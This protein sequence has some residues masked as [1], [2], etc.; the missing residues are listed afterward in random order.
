MKTLFLGEL[1]HGLVLV[2]AI[3]LAHPVLAQWQGSHY[4]SSHHQDN[5]DEFI[6]NAGYHVNAAGDPVFEDP[7][8]SRHYHGNYYNHEKTRNHSHPCK[9]TNPDVPKDK[10]NCSL[11]DDDWDQVNNWWDHCPNTPRGVVVDTYGCPF[12]DADAD[13]VHDV[14]DNCDNTSVFA[15]VNGYGCPVDSDLDGVADHNDDCDSTSKGLRVDRFGCPLD[16]DSDGVVDGSDSCVWSRYG[17][18]VD[19]TGC[20]Y[21]GLGKVHFDTDKAEVTGD[22]QSKLLYLKQ[23]MDTNKDAILVIRGYADAR[24]GDSYNKQLSDRRARAIANELLAMG[25]DA[26]RLTIQG[27]GETR[28]IA[29]DSFSQGRAMNRRVEAYVLRDIYGANMVDSLR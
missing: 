6:N 16:G 13:E 17:E 4:R 29:Y 27:H 22:H 23:M 24:S 28:P 18:L 21:Q 26:T 3:F 2:L 25:I 12:E 19:A 14:V 11:E 20:Q 1:K 5:V 10:Y 15:T 7:Y 8:Y 9:Y